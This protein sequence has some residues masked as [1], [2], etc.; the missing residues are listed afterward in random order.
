MTVNDGPRTIIIMIMISFILITT[1]ITTITITIIITTIRMISRMLLPPD[2]TRPHTGRH[3]NFS[4]LPK[5][6]H[7]HQ[8]HDHNYNHHHHISHHH[9]NSHYHWHNSHDQCHN[10]QFSI[11]LLLQIWISY[12]SKWTRPDAKNIPR[13]FTTKIRRYITYLK[14][15]RYN[16]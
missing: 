15:D 7:R 13:V 6:V 4:A 11:F 12:C 3:N 14:I 1:I 16:E 10:H 8:H 9:H 2:S 5:Q